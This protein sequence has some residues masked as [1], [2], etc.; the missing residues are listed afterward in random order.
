MNIPF[1]ELLLHNF[2][3]IYLNNQNEVTSGNPL[4]VP[5]NSEQ[6]ISTLYLDNGSILEGQ[7]VNGKIID[8]TIGTLKITV[9]KDNDSYVKVYKGP[10]LDNKPNGE[11]ITSV[12]GEYIYEG[13]VKDG[14][15]DGKGKYH[16]LKL[17]YIYEGNFKDNKREGEGWMHRLQVLYALSSGRGHPGHIL[18]LEP[19]VHRGEEEPCKIRIRTQHRNAERACIRI[20]V[21]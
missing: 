3:F 14:K 4:I 8:N 18:Q 15:F 5:N 12:D 1:K 9:L 2:N 7:I 16:S 13:Y 19:H 10:F 11:G 20:S 17:N 6:S 21:H